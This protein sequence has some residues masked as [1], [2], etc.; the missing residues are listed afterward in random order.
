[1]SA[2]PAQLVRR[3]EAAYQQYTNASEQLRHT[4]DPAPA[5]AAMA[6][7]SWDVAMAWR[8]IATSAPLPWWS[9]AAVRA[10]ADA[11]EAQ[12]HDWHA[13]STAIKPNGGARKQ[14]WP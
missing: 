3:W 10:A 8:D 2:L 1:M 6:S 4:T 12:A 13:K 7:A 11:F 9:L 14:A 5:T